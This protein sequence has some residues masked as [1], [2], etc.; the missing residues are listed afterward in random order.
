[1]GGHCADFA[2]CRSNGEG[3][4]AGARVSLPD[5]EGKTVSRSDLRGKV[6]MLFFWT[7]LVNTCKGGVTPLQKLHG[8]LPRQGL[9]VLMIDI[10]K[11]PTGSA[12]S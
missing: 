3:L 2:A 5:L 6:V 1:V 12:E 11:I 4:E 10:R 8:D 7:N 9:E